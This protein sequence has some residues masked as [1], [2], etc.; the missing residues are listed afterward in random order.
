M[1]TIIAQVGH[2][3]SGEVGQYY[4]GADRCAQQCRSGTL[5]SNV[6]HP[7]V[8][9]MVRE[10]VQQMNAECTYAAIKARVRAIYGE[11]SNGSALTC[12]IICVA[13]NHL[14]RIHYSENKKP[15]LLSTRYADLFHTG[16]GKAMLY[17]P[18]KH[19]A[20]EIA[21][22]GDDDLIVRLADGV[23][24]NASAFSGIDEASE[25]AYRTFA[26]KSHQR[27]YF[28]RNLVGRG[29][30]ATLG[31][32]LRYMGWVKAH[33]AGRT[34]YSASSSQRTSARSFAMRRRKCQKFG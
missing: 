23:G 27:D 34:K 6:D 14:S 8:W 28:A 22:F 13:V 33:L 4:S 26:L 18:E 16:R 21:K 2:F 5:V 11:D 15:R 30:D 1:A 12:R 19:G 31:Q 20:W 32:I 9:R 24:E 7:P 3:Y 10:T 29:P 17:D 25:E